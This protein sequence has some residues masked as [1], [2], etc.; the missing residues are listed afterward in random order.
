MW[1]EGKSVVGAETE[2]ETGAEIGGARGAGTGA[3]KEMA[4]IEGGGIG[5]IAV[6]GT[7]ELAIR[8]T[9]KTHIVTVI[10]TVGTT[11]GFL[12]KLY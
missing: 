7:T 8:N 3:V 12:S 5:G 6:I 9:L 11:V 2:A 10:G 4:R 1:T